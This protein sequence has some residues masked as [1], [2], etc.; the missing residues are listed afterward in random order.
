[1]QKEAAVASKTAR[2]LK[3]KTGL[4]ENGGAIP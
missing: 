2:T 1:M 3:N 4:R